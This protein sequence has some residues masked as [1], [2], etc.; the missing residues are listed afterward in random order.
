VAAAYGDRIRWTQRD[1]GGISAARNHG[2]EMAGGEF[3]AFLDADDLWTERKLE[4]QVA[5]L[6]ADPELGMVSGDMEQFV[7]P[8]LAGRLD[9]KVQFLAGEVSVRMPG[10]VLLRRREFDRVGRFSTELTTGE[11]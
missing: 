10:S 2:I 11:F 5:A 8:E 3:L 4:R 1:H 9:A 7:S 6:L